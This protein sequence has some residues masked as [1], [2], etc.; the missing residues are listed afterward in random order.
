MTGDEA[1][2]LCAVW[3]ERLRLRD[4]DVG[5]AL[6][7][8]DPTADGTKYGTITWQLHAKT[9]RITLFESADRAAH[10]PQ[11]APERTIVHELLHLWFIFTD[12]VDGSAEDTA[13]EQAIWAIAQA[14][15]AGGS[16]V[17]SQPKAAGR[18]TR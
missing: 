15:V 2:A 18:P 1:A 11:Y 14:L 13:L 8:P 7:A 12:T 4:W 9:A 6:V 17:E 10:D 5:V 3:Q 16:H